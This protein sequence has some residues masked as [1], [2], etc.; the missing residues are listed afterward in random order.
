MRKLSE[1]ESFGAIDADN[2]DILNDCFEDHEAFIDLLNFK[3]ISY[4]W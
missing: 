3:K 1:I 4:H 2:D